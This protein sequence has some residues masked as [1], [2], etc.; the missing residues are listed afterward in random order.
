MASKYQCFFYMGIFILSNWTNQSSGRKLHDTSMPEMHERWMV[1]YGRVYKDAMEKE[2]RLK[3][4][5]EN[6]EFI[7][8][9]NNAGE[10]P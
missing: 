9:F 1:R 8:S 6:V 7:E 10:K 2:Q 5:K 4:C 3:I